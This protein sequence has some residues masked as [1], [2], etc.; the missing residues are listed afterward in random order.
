MKKISLFL[1]FL[2][3]LYYLCAY[4]KPKDNMEV[5]LNIRLTKEIR[6]KYKMFCLKKDMIISDR[7]RKLIEMDMNGEI[8][9]F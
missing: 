7:I 3:F 2:I 4:M 9:Q 6:K 1:S 8:K 5:R